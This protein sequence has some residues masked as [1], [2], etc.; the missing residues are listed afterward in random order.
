MTVWTFKQSDIMHPKIQLMC[1]HQISD[2]RAQRVQKH[3]IND[4][5][6]NVQIWLCM[7]TC[8]QYTVCKNTDLEIQLLF[9]RQHNNPTCKHNQIT[10][11]THQTA[12][13]RMH[14][15]KHIHTETLAKSKAWTAK[16]LGIGRL[17][18]HTDRSNPSLMNLVCVILLRLLSL[19]QNIYVPHHLKVLVPV[20]PICFTRFLKFEV[21]SMF[22]WVSLDR[23]GLSIKPNITNHTFASRGFTISRYNTL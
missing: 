5:G 12:F 16:I 1:C 2:T 18:L 13:P 15:Q 4:E 10:K 14:T 19:S 6:R 7:N 17:E 11:R 3:T 8:V 9:F 23:S 21:K 20:T 22:C